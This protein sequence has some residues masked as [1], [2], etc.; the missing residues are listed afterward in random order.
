MASNLKVFSLNIGMSDNL[1]GLVNFIVNES[2]DIIFLQEV[3]MTSEHLCFQ[4]N[5]L[6]YLAEV[7]INEDEPTKPGTALLW[8][9]CLPVQDVTN[10]VQCRCQIAFMD[11]FLLV[12]IYAHSGSDKRHHRGELFAND[13]FQFFNVH[14]SSS[15]IFGGDFN[16]VLS[17]YDI[18]E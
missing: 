3:K 8:K 17:A 15:I 16:S 6:G 1:A 10:L 9:S 5:K 12:N 18:E 7:N 4:V 14:K 2:L 11:Q 13:L